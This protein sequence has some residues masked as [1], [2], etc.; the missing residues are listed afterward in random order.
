MAYKLLLVEDDV[1]LQEILSDYF[2]ERSCGSFQIHTAATGEEGLQKST[3]SSHDPVA[4]DAM[5]PGT[6]G[7]A[8]CRELRKQ[9]DVPIVFITARQNE[10]DRLYGYRLG[11]DDYISKPFSLAELYAKTCA[12]LK[13]AKGTVCGGFMRVGAIQLDPHRYIVFV[14]DKEVILAPIEF[15]ILKILMENRGRLVSRESLLTGIW[16][17]DFEGNERVVDNHVK[18]LRKSL[19]E[20]SVQIKTVIKKGYK[21]EG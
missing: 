12:L 18:K 15:S 5:L 4:M 17:Y 7:F 11:C 10:E 2:S 6:D 21:L 8:L 14:Q 16:G 3:D 9:G 1:E 13:R 19:G 20:A